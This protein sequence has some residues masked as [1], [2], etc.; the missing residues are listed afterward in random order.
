MCIREPRASLASCHRRLRFGATR[1][2]GGRSATRGG[3]FNSHTALQA[4][5]PSEKTKELNR[6]L[7]ELAHEEEAEENAAGGLEEDG[8]DDD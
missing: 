6:K 2:E 8:D 5:E 1:R 3:E 4:E 7:E